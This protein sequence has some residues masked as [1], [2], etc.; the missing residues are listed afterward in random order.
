MSDAGAAPTITL[1]S[2]VFR[3]EREAGWLAL[4]QLAEKI[5]KRG[6][7]SLTADELASLPMLYRGAVSSLSVARA[8]ALDRHLLLYLED[9]ALRGFLL[10]YG[11]RR[12]WGAGVLHFFRTGFP[13]AARA[14]KWHILAALMCIVAGTAAG[15]MLADADEAWIATLIPSGIAGGRGPAST[16]ESLLANEL[17]A[18]WPGWQESFGV[19][20]SFLFQHNTM[21]GILCFGLGAASGI[22]TAALLIFQ[23]L[24][25]GAFLALHAH[26]GLLIDCLGW[27]SIHGITE[28]GAITLCGAGGFFI[29]EKILLPGRYSRAD[30]LAMH[31]QTASRLAVGA[32][33][34]FMIAAMLEGGLRQLVASTP[35]R[36]IIG[37]GVGALWIAYLA[38]PRR[39]RA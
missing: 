13:A 32:M 11:P 12:S 5:R 26:R 17:F 39:A 34:L 19:F 38:W 10:V 30:S 1:K 22:P 3:R 24:S 8:I 25:F 36:F 4:E 16:R 2:H 28:F 15:F 37:I 14:A 21:V 27:V 23:G 7:R 31:G 35:W 29:A 9:L 20:A 33:L 18:P 6:L